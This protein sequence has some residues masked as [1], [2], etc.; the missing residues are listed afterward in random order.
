MIIVSDTSPLHYL[1]LLGEVE[2]L[3]RLYATVLCPREVMRECLDL[4]A[5]ASLRL[6]A[7]EPP[8]WLVIKEVAAVGIDLL[9]A[10]DVAE[11]LR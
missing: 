3:P 10:L 8:G 2:L 4:Q 9:S 11:C 7:T 6:W 1:V 5:P